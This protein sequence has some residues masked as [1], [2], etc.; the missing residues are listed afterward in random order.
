[1]SGAFCPCRFEEW[2]LRLIG[3]GFWGSFLFFNFSGYSH[4]KGHQVKGLD[5]FF[6][7]GFFLVHDISRISLA[8]SIM[9]GLFN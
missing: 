7:F 5:F 2:K 4:S 1:M 3:M 8:L 9:E 6:L